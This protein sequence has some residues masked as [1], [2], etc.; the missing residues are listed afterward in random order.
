[1][2]LAFVI[3]MLGAA[4]IVVRPG[5]GGADWGVVVLGS[6]L[7]AATTGILAS[8]LQF[9]PQRLFAAAAVVGGALVAAGVSGLLYAAQAIWAAPTPSS[10]VFVWAGA[11][12]T[13]LVITRASG[14]RLPPAR[15]S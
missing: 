11:A 8:I 10:T 15:P 5:S 4:A 7:T 3:A 13:S 9:L 1:M 14:V 6:T 12:I 2:A